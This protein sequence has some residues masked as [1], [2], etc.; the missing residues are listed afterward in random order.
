MTEPDLVVI[1]SFRVVFALERRLFKI[2]R[3]RLPLPYGLPV[4]GLVYAAAA[5]VGVLVAGRLPVIGSLLGA[6]PAPARFVGL[7]AVVAWLLVRARVD[8]RPAHD[9]LWA[10]VRYHATARQLVA[11]RAVR[12][13][14]LACVA[15]P[16]V[17][18]ADASGGVYRRARIAGPAR[19]WLRGPA[20]ACQRADTLTVVPTGGWPGQG[21]VVDLDEGE[22]LI[23]RSPA[24][25]C[26][27]AR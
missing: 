14:S 19:V 5:L 15:E 18:A 13:R 23:V 9:H 2:D 16:V 20:K 27:G 12:G 24:R 10:L 11:L 4:R 21:C 22:S 25:G 3:W 1:R 26:G 7:P 6:L 17:I 8:G